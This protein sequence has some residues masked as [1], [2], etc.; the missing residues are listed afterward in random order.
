[1]SPRRRGESC[2]LP[3]YSLPGW[4]LPCCAAISAT[5]SGAVGLAVV[6]GL[7]TIVIYTD[8]LTPRRVHLRPSPVAI[9]WLAD[10]ALRERA[11]QAEAA[12]VH[13]LVTPLVREVGLDPHPVPLS[14]AIL[15][16]LAGGA[17]GV[18]G[19]GLAATIHASGKGWAIVIPTLTWAV[20]TAAAIA[21][22][23]IAGLLPAIRAARLSPNDA[24]RTV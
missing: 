17:L 12:E 7:A 2:S 23:A 4:P 18:G 21:I 3:A 14:D 19:G 11:E 6:L 20:W 13:A 22:G 8:R 5:T 16:A 1:M 10:Y 24:L 9:G 15:L